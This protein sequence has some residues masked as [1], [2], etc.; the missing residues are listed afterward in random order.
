M[1]VYIPYCIS[2][3]AGLE[4]LASRHLQRQRLKSCKWQERRCRSLSR[5]CLSCHNELFWTSLHSRVI[6]A[7][8][9]ILHS[10][11]LHTEP[12]SA[13]VVYFK[14]NLIIYSCRLVMI[15]NSAVWCSPDEHGM[16]YLLN[17]IPLKVSSSRHLRVFPCH[18]LLSFGH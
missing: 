18:C 17:M 3:T 9:C 13:S 16:G 11:L 14:C 12:I 8:C 1:Y 4:L 5:F 2:A 15:Y 6:C 7:A 10:S